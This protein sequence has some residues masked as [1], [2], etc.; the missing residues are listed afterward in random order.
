MYHEGY[1]ETQQLQQAN[2]NKPSPPPAEKTDAAVLEANPNSSAT[3]LP[4]IEPHEKGKAL[5]YE[6]DLLFFGRDTK[7]KD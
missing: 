6:A 5:V 1:Q 3:S 2:S 4:S 7:R